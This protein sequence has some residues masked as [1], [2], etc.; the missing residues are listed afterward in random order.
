MYI[1]YDCYMY[2]HIYI[3]VCVC[4][5]ARVC[6]RIIIAIPLHCRYVNSIYEE[7][8]GKAAYRALEQ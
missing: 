4:V 5:C 3:C 6:A 7:R 8:N 1:Q 2:I